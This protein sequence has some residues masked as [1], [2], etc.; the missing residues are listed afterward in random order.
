ML[1]SLNAY[2]DLQCTEPDCISSYL[3]SY[4]VMKV[5][6]LQQNVFLCQPSSIVLPCTMQHVNVCQIISFDSGQQGNA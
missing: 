2:D 3:L 5:L 4:L 6:L 1:D